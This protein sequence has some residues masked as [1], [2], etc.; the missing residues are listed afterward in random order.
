IDVEAARE[1]GILVIHTPDAATSAVADLTLGLM[2]ALVRRI[3][4]CDAA[5]RAGRFA[6]ERSQYETPELSE[7]TLGIVG[8]GRIGKAV[9]RRCYHGFAMRILYNDILDAQP[10]DFEATP[11]DK[12]QLFRQADV[13]SLHLPLTEQTRRLID[14]EALTQFKRGSFLINTARGAVVDSA[15][16]AHALESG[17]LAGAALDVFDPEPLPKG[18]PLLTAPHTLFTPHVGARSR[19]GLTRMN[20]VVDEVIRTLE[21]S[22]AVS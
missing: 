13:V 12:A 20:A 7:L 6:E 5:V 22:R 1:R 2:I 9:A 17:Q 10:L 8:L 11:T 14:G 4:T 19:T 16:L 15:A 21:E 18:H 3:T